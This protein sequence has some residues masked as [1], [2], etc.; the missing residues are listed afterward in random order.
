MEGR[1]DST[2]LSRARPPSSLLTITPPL[3]TRRKT[4]IRTDSAPSACSDGRQSRERTVAVANVIRGL[5]G[6]SSSP[7]CCMRN[8]STIT[9]SGVKRSAANARHCKSNR[10]TCAVAVSTLFVCAGHADS[11][12]ID[13]LP[14]SESTMTE[15][16]RDEPDTFYGSSTEETSTIENRVLECVVHV[17]RSDRHGTLRILSPIALS[18]VF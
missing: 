4:T 16:F 10:T 5:R 15:V 12:K 17:S 3:E 8:G 14:H 7:V 1:S 9:H 13:N 6:V 2:L 11:M 18:C